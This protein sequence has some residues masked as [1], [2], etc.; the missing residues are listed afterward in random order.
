MSGG[1]S[2]GDSRERWRSGGAEGDIDE[3]GCDLSELTILSSPNQAVIETLTVDNVL[4]IE[5]IEQIPQRLVAKTGDN[6]IAG[7]ITSKKMPT[8]AACIREGFQYVAVVLSIDGGRVE[9]RVQRQ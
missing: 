6:M 8:I 1:G 7:T 9:V 2:G 3:D 5:L 4:T